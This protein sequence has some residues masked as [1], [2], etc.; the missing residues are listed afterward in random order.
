MT[1]WT[2]EEAIELCGKIEMIAP[3][4]GCHVA[5]TGGCLYKPGKRKDVD[6]LIYR[7][8]QEEEIDAVGL[9]AE[10]D[11]RLNIRLLKCFGW[12]AKAYIPSDAGAED[13][14][15]IDFFFPEHM[16]HNLPVE[17][18]TQEQKDKYGW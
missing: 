7:I 15:D 16:A 1:K 17:H 9:M 10:L 3:R 13:D 12:V 5:L 18:L 4:Y 2:R 14:M 11:N 8:R 6:I